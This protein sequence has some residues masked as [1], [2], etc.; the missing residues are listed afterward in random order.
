MD[1][2]EFFLGY[3]VYECLG[4]VSWTAALSLGHAARAPPIKLRDMWELWW[5]EK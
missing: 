1:Q 4:L 3:I 5:I 2:S